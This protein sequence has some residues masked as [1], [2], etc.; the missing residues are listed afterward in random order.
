MKGTFILFL[1]FSE[2]EK[3]EMEVCR[4]RKLNLVIHSKKNSQECANITFQT[5]VTRPC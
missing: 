2:T 1:K 5:Y 3:Y 4:K